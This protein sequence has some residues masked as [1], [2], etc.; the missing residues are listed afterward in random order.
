LKIWIDILTPKQLLFS[1]FI[2][3]KLS[4]N[5]EIICTSRSYN[6]VSKL[7]QIRKF[8]VIFV[9]KHGGGWK[10]TKFNAHLDRM[11]KLSPLI[12]KFSPDLTISFCSPE[13]ARISFGLGIKHVAFCDSPHAEAL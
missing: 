2:I 9:G 4:K 12:T 7:S 5:N 8:N 11:K 3:K 13:A 10:S 1:E 6:E